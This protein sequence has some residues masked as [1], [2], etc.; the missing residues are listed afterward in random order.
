M[1]DRR[2]AAL[3][4]ALAA[5]GLADASFWPAPLPEIVTLVAVAA[6]AAIA[7]DRASWRRAPGLY[8][9]VGFLGVWLA[10]GVIR[11]PVLADGLVMGLRYASGP[12]LALAAVRLATADAR[13]VTEAVAAGAAVPALGSYA[14]WAGDGWVYQADHWRLAGVFGFVLALA[15]AASLWVVV[16]ALTAASA[17]GRTR[18]V[19]AGLLVAGAPLL[20]ASGTRASVL[21][22]AVGVVAGLAALGRRREALG[23]VGVAVVAIAAVPMLRERVTE[24]VLAVGGVAPDRGW[25]WLGT[26]R[27]AIWTRSFA[28]FRELPA[29]DQWL[30]TG[31]GGYQHF[32]KGK[33]PHQEALVLLYQL[34]PVGVI[35]YGGL[36][37]LGVARAWRWARAEWPAAL[38]VGL[39]VAALVAG[40]TSSVFLTRLSTTWVF[41]ALV[42]A[43]WAPPERR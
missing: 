26:G 4:V 3:L 1:T 9:W 28:A 36:V 13:R 20:V 11:A 24:L 15:S 30:G 14:A 17:T 5:R 8:A 22:A 31:L 32:W 35:A 34:G 12:I 2:S 18:L 6:A 7:V 41:F 10:V 23:A 42:G 33:D 25:E 38:A 19:G 21:F 27:V 43:F 39:G 29:V 37:V 16:G 40:M